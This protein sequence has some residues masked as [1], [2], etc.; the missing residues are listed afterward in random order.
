MTLCAIACFAGPLHLKDVR[1]YLLP[2]QSTQCIV[3][4]VAASYAIELAYLYC[5]FDVELISLC[6][7]HA[8]YDL[9]TT[10][11]SLEQSFREEY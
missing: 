3:W 4:I 2:I 11:R 8:L 9:L 5:V 1:K 10:I 6:F 7:R